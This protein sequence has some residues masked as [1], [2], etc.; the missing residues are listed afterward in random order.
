[1]PTW[2]LITLP[3]QL[4]FNCVAPTKTSRC[5]NVC[6]VTTQHHKASPTCSCPSTFVHPHP[7]QYLLLHLP[8]FL[9]YSAGAQACATAAVNS[10]YGGGS[11]FASAAA[12]ASAIQTALFNQLLATSTAAASAVSNANTQIT[13]GATNNLTNTIQQSICNPVTS[14][15]LAHAFAQSIVTTTGC[16]GVVTQA[17]ASMASPV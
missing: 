9:R 10:Y 6:P 5:I 8:M 14:T 7:L 4:W 2:L 1:M 11:A 3:M 15:A 16:N 17:I 13:T 12:Q